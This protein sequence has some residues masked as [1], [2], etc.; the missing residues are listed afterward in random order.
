M[1][2]ERYVPKTRD[3][4]PLTKTYVEWHDPFP[5][6]S[7]TVKLIFHGLFS[8]FFDGSTR[9][10]AGTHNTTQRPG[11]P[12]T[13]HPHEYM[14]TIVTKNGVLTTQVDNFKVNTGNPLEVSLLDIH[15][16][17]SA[18]PGGVAP[19]VYAYTGP[20]H[21]QFARNPTDDRHDWRWM[22]DFEDKMYPGGVKGKIPAAIAPGVNI[23]N[24]LFYTL[25]R[26]LAQFDLIPETGGGAIIPLNS[27]AEVV[28]ADIYLTTDGFVQLTGGPVGNRKL[29]FVPN[30]FYEVTITN[31]CDGNAHAACKYKGNASTKQERNDFFL[32]YETFDP[33]LNQ[34][35]YMLVKRGLGDATDDAPCGGVG[36]GGSPPP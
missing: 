8:F 14:V 31:L 6:G 16:E 33:A 2:K 34:P 28:A 4:T 12:H 25:K 27:V 36:Y 32:H 17:G 5:A 22:I 1:S 3:A 21:A 19:G 35:E 24:G 30:R 10:F 15:V 13:N 23:N 26:T 29:D 11:H 9:C 20:G 7:P 18:F